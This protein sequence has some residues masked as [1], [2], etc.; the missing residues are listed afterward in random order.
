MLFPSAVTFTY[1]HT[2]NLL[3]Y[4]LLDTLVCIG[5]QFPKFTVGL[6]TWRG[7]TLFSN[8]VSTLASFPG[9]PSF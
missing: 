1:I 3:P 9:L 8:T 5:N 6:G 7:I 4:I 2:L